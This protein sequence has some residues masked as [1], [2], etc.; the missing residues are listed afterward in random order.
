[1]STSDPGAV[2]PPGGQPP[3]PPPGQPIPSDQIDNGVSI[4][5]GGK[6]PRFFKSRKT[7]I[8]TSPNGLPPD[9]KGCINVGKDGQVE[10]VEMPEPA[11]TLSVTRTFDYLTWGYIDRLFECT[12][13]T[14]DKPFAARPVGHLMLM[15]VSGRIEKSGRCPMTF[16]FGIDGGEDVPVE[17]LSD[18][19]RG[20]WEYIWFAYS[21]DVAAGETRLG[22]KVIGV[23]VEQL[24][25]K[26]DY[27]VLGLG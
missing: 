25:D 4:E 8:R 14:N 20:P 18:Q 5:I 19:H 11:I 27:S 21:D 22:K 23:Y 26:A 15:G 6:P 10:G 7:V 9:Y 13:H 1:V 24:V 17:G 3:T 16:K 2:T 12:W